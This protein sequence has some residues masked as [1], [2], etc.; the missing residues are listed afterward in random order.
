MSEIRR[1]E[2]RMNNKFPFK[3]YGNLKRTVND[4]DVI[5]NWHDNL[6]LQLCTKG[7]GYV[8]LDSKKYEIKQGDIVVINPD[9]VHLTL[10]YDCIEIS[11]IIVDSNFNIMDKNLYYSPIINDKEIEKIFNKISNESDN[12]KLTKYLLEI[13]IILKEKHCCK[14]QS[15]TNSGYFNIV[16]NSIRYIKENYSKKI[17]IDDIAKKVQINKYTLSKEFKKLTNKTI[18]DYI[19]TY[20]IE[21]VAH[22]ILKGENITTSAYNCGFNNLSYF[23]NVF[24][25]YK[26]V[27]PSEYKK[28]LEQRTTNH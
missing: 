7:N 5:S 16:K 26:G 8:F 23:T 1:E 20:R 9:V 3:Y 24:K 12:L 15:I 14:N 27:L 4:K 2:H 28:H 25:K 17:T 22:L 19:N 13:L 6:E 10:A 18:V 11:G 21:K